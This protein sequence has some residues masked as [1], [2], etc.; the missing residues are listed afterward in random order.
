VERAFETSASPAVTWAHLA[1][2]ERWPT[3][4]R[5]I[6]RVELEPRGAL[7]P[8]SA[9]RIV[10]RPGIPTTFRVTRLDPGHSWSWR[11]RFLGTTLDYDHTI[12]AAGTG[13]LITF[14]ID[15]SGATASF[16]GRA[17]ATIYR[18]ILD[19]AIANLQRE[20]DAL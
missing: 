19:R 10:L 18:R 11:G 8:T 3:W 6:R 13:A 7:T 1:E 12:E 20:L 16:V 4:A 9:G 2:V 17:F 5:H 15:G 14:T